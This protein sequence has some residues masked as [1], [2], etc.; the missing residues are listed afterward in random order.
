MTNSVTHWGGSDPAC[1][2][3]SGDLDA[4]QN[5]LTDDI[6]I[7]EISSRE[8][9]KWGFLLLILPWRDI[10]ETFHFDVAKRPAGGLN[11]AKR[12]LR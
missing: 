6:W 11:S 5:S 10:L 2:I 8:L 9:Q 3:H 4:D 7:L 12:T 1:I